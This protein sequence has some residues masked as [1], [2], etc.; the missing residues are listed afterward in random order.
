MLTLAATSLTALILGVMAERRWRVGARKLSGRLLETVVYV[1]MPIV[2]FLTIIE[3]KL[4][5]AVGAG[6][7]FGLTERVVAVAAAWL[8]ATRLIALNRPQT[9]ALMAVTA[10]ANTGYLGI[11][12]TAMLIGSNQIGLAVAYENLVNAPAVLV[13]GFGVGAVFGTKSGSTWKQRLTAFLTRNPP[14]YALIVALFMPK[15]VA[16][17]WGVDVAHTLA[18]GIAPVGFFALG[19]NLML[20][21][22]E[23]GVRVFPPPMTPAIAAAIGIRLAVAPTVM[24]CLSSLI[25]SV[26]HTFLLEAAMPSGI[27]ALVVA[28]LYGLD[29][30]ITVGAI[31]WSTAIVVA[32]AAVAAAF[33]G[34]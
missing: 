30:K 24:I 31:T 23:T 13:I 7:A 15:S 25:V 22:D 21:H 14:L 2:V 33:G 18:L 3:L 1:V 16:P 5:G 19:V 29:M 28:H 6:L 34:F 4:T 8:V 10:I 12:L 11:P 20:E 32:A 17:S 27:N 26:P 9:G